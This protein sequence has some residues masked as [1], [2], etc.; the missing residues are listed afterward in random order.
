MKLQKKKHGVDPQGGFFTYLNEK[1]E[2]YDTDK[3]FFCLFC[4]IFKISH[5]PQI[6]FCSTAGC[7]GDVCFLPKFSS[8]D[9]L[10]L[11]SNQITTGVY[12][13]ACMSAKYAKID[14]DLSNK[15]MKIAEEGFVWLESHGKLKE[16]IIY[17]S[18]SS[19]L[20]F[21]FEKKPI[22]FKNKTAPEGPLNFKD[23]FFF[24]I[25]RAGNPIISPFNIYSESFVVMACSALYERKPLPQYR[26]QGLASMT[27]YM[28]RLLPFALFLSF[29]N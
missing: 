11:K 29:S 13:F 24:A 10:I 16:D 21:F 28:N 15:C 8:I 23:N 20:L 2:V 4:E 12:M 17:E 3:V 5:I 19:S 7:N 1:G 22:N 26:D 14:E 18:I 6:N 27:N 25:D 9:S